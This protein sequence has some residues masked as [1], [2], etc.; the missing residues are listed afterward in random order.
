MIA[1]LLRLIK[2]QK[3]KFGLA[4]FLACATI[5]AGIGLMSTSGY[6]ISRAAQRPLIVD[7][8]MV[9]AAVRFFGISRAVVRYFERIVSHDLTFRIMCSMRSLVFENLNER[10]LAWLMG[11]RPGDLLARLVSD[12]ETLQNAYLRII[13]PVIVAFIISLITVSTLWFI[14]PA[15]A[16]TTLFF[17]ALS[18]FGAPILATKLSRGRGK[19]DIAIKTGLKVSLVDKFQGMQDLLW[20][21]QEKK[22]R[23]ELK[24][25]QK[26]IDG[27]QKKNAGSAGLLEGLNSLF[28]NLGMFSLLIIASPM[29]LSGE[30]KGVM[31]AMLT[32][33]V[34]SS[35]EA[36]QPLGQAF[37]FLENSKEC[38]R[39]MQATTSGEDQQ[40]KH[41]FTT[42]LPAKHDIRFEQVSFSYAQENVTI[43]DVTFEIPQGSKTAT[44]GPTG[45][46][47]S[48]LVNLLLRFWNPDKGNIIIGESDL[49][50][51][52]PAQLRSLFGLVQQDAYIFNRSL[53]ENLLIAKPM[54]S[55]QELKN[56]LESVDLK[57]LASDLD[58]EPGSLGMKL[59]GGQRQLL[60][61]ARSLLK[62]APVWIFDEP[63]ANLDVNTER[64]ILDRIWA[65]SQNRT[66]IMITHRLIDMEKMDQIIV[67]NK[68]KIIEKGTHQELLAK[69]S[70]YAR[71]LQSQHQ[72]ISD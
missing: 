2:D 49:R 16:L 18:G 60:A 25:L 53:R 38:F 3:L 35:F 70:L 46:G 55:D 72:I 11:R 42:G 57:E 12:I 34:L 28:A 66:M 5:I 64:R 24:Q 54:A 50:E 69:P 17:L 40:Q 37:L 10:P 26:G 15:L 1:E 19:A 44:I 65:N 71:M 4:L 43:D 41:D 39:R 67:M 13:S 52:D 30:I 20:L 32:L 48:T 51:I 8:F 22:A 62:D 56:V 21:G 63:T 36:V 27:I 33:G 23:E 29:V 9:T 14:G 59:S 45:S 47:K 58:R 31:L 7:L 68:G 61:L 6:L